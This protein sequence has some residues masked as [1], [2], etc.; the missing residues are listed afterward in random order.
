MQAF[1]KSLP[2]DRILHGDECD[3]VDILRKDEGKRTYIMGSTGAKLTYEHAITI[4]TR[5]ASSL[6]RLM[7]NYSIATMTDTRTNAAIR[8]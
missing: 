8:E 4:L 6:V 1:C 7:P 2:K 5:Y 3:L